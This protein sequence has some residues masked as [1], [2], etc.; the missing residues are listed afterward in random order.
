MRKNSLI[1]LGL[2]LIHSSCK[3]T[4]SPT[5]STV[6]RDSAI[7]YSLN[8]VERMKRISSEINISE[9]VEIMYEKTEKARLL[10]IQDY[11]T[12]IKWDSTYPQNYYLRAVEYVELAEGQRRELYKKALRDYNSLVLL[13]S[14]NIQNYLERGSFY[15]Y[16]LKDTVKACKDLIKYYKVERAGRADLYHACKCNSERDVFI[17]PD[18]SLIDWTKEK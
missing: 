7:F 14:T 9:G 8:G 10:A 15:L 2:C 11:T 6:N 16:Q 18:S 5:I 13:D 4:S 12:G 17:W 3:Q 1:L